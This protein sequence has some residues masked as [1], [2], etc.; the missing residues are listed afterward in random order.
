MLNSSVT[1]KLFMALS[2]I[3]LIIFLTQH[4]LI[5]LTS[6]ISLD[7]FNTISH[8]MGTN[9]LVQYVL[10]PILML[11]VLFHFIM[12]FVLE[13]KNSRAR[14]R[15]YAK[16]NIGDG[17]SWA[18]RNMIISGTVILSFLFIHFYDFWIHE[19]T[20]KYIQGDMS[21][22]STVFLDSGETIEEF[23]YWK[24][25]NAKFHQNIV[26]VIAYCFSFIALGLHL[27]H[28]FSSSIQS[29]GVGSKR[30]KIIKLISLLYSIIIPLGFSLIAI[31]HYLY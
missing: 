23:R 3:F 15:G 25:L 16:A 11:G 29:I 21:G 30:F 18:S 19:M 10:Q 28:G 5:N 14:V 4:L 12:G 22:K 24:E 1:R 13:L 6:L 9:P 8:F 26:I 2:G 17:S 7:L 27:V 20:V 31:Y